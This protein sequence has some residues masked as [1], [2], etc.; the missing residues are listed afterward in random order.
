VFFE[1]ILLLDKPFFEPREANKIMSNLI[2]FDKESLGEGK[3]GK[4][5]AGRE[6]E[7]NPLFTNWRV[8]DAGDGVKAGVWEVTPGAYRAIKGT[9]WEFCSILSGVSEITEDGREAVVMRAGDAFVM[10]PGF[11][12]VWRCIET[13]RKIWVVRERT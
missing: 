11:T 10:K 6:V 1:K 2:K 9:T 4:P 5:I 3:P 12:G 13:T 8:D 7:G